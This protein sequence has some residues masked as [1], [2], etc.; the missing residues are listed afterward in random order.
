M[1]LSQFASRAAARLTGAWRLLSVLALATASIPFVA[2]IDG[3]RAKTPGKTYC[4]NRTCHRVLTLAETRRQIGRSRSVLAS[5]Y[6]NCRLDRYNPCGLTS[7]G[8][9]F[10]PSR[11]D[12]AASPIYPNGTK[13]LVWNPSNRRTVVVRIDNAGPYWGKRTLDLSRAA[14]DR[15]GFRHRGIARLKVSVLSAP[16]RSQARYRARRVYAPVR[17]YIGRFASLSMAIAAGGGRVSTGLTRL[18]QLDKAAL[19]KT[20]PPLPV[21]SA[22]KPANPGSYKLPPQIVRQERLATKPAPRRRLAALSRKSTAQA[23]SRT[24]RTKRA[25]PKLRTTKSRLKKASNRRLATTTR[26]SE[27][28]NAAKSKRAKL[29]SVRKKIDRRRRSQPRNPN[30]VRSKQAHQSA[31]AKG[32]TRARSKSKSAIA[33]RQAPARKQATR[34]AIPVPTTKQK[35]TTVVA[36]PSKRWRQKYFSPGGSD[37]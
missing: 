17:G 28:R 30:K 8:A 31:T 14:A 7:S 27:R 5:Y 3:A 29:S 4:F 2:A 22:I 6:R 26:K 11:P 20:K 12:N 18:A 23:S 24:K 35:P 10:R 9:V 36:Q 21:A 33:A 25:T 37:A 15:L 13:L 32:N 1:P 16:T 34:S 19:P